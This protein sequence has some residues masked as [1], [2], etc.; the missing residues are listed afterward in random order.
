MARL[1]NKVALITGAASN[2]GLGYATAERF[3]REGARLA[4]TDI[5]EQ[6]L[7]RCA[8]EM[9]AL[10]AEVI[11]WRQDVS[12]EADWVDTY[13]R[14]DD[15]YG[16]LDVLVNNAGIAILRT[17]DEL[18]LQEY[19]RQM[20]INMTGVFLGTKLALPLLRNSGGGSIINMS[21][22]C[23]L[24]GVPGT[25]AYTA[26][27]AGVHVFCKTV[28]MEC[29]KDN[30]RCN[31]VHPGLIWTNIQKASLEDNPEQYDILCNSVPLGRLG[32]AEEVASCVLFLASDDASYVTGTE[33]V[34]DGGLIAQ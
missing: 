33:L 13:K 28:A 34:V 4:L 31:S 27:K 32:K 18:T 29:A 21:S 20:D 25:A 3:A 2:P 9:R 22:V 19:Q 23:G 5:D 14:I 26:S 12:A 1:N 24:V 15:H 7:A 17:I 10:G 8:E 30:I 11:S 16:R 6:G